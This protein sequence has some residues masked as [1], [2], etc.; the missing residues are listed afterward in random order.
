MSIMLPSF[1]HVA[2]S[3]SFVPEMVEPITKWG[4]A[5]TGELSAVDFSVMKLQLYDTI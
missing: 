3:V 4:R 1:V 2:P 5:K